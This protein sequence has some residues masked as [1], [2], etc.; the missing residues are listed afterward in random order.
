MPLLLAIP[1]GLLIGGVLGIVGAGGS[2]IAVPALVYGIGL[3]PGEAIPA[4]L[5]I[6][7]LSSAVAVLPRIRRGVDWGTAAGFWF[8]AR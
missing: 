3:S 7:G 5:I 1:L 2:I 6:V 4:S 8:Q